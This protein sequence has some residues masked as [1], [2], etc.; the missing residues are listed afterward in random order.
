MMTKPKVIAYLKEKGNYD[1]VD[2]ILIDEL[3]FHLR[4]IKEAKSDIKERGAVIDTKD[5]ES[6]R[7]NPSVALYNNTVKTV[8]TLCRKL[9]LDP[10]SRKELELDKVIENDGFDD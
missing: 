2:L 9:G 1:K 8:M 10:R 7:V 6:K 3:M 4:L 5:G